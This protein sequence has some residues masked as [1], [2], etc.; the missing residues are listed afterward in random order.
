M[1]DVMDQKRV[2]TIDLVNTRRPAK[3]MENNAVPLYILKLDQSIK[4]EA[5]W[6]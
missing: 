4:N 3:V 2:L 5:S 1:N 6:K